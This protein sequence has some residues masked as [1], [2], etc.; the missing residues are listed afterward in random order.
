MRGLLLAAMTAL[1]LLF[2]LDQS[3]AQRGAPATAREQHSNVHFRL[4]SVAE[5]AATVR[6][7]DAEMR[8]HAPS[9]TAPLALTNI[10]WNDTF[11]LSPRTPFAAGQGSLSVYNTMV[12][13]PDLDPSGLIR[14]NPNSRLDL[15]VINPARRR[16]LVE[17]SVH[18]AG[19]PGASFQVRLGPSGVVLWQDASTPYENVL[20]FL[21]PATPPGAGPIDEFRIEYNHANDWYLYGCQVTRLAL[22]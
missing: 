10:N 6:R 14:L 19:N 12:Y 7:L 16:L 11:A 3:Q 5:R 4:R 9:P 18:G 2:T 1:F 20:S 15:L 21:T 17:C 13:N 22:P 8:R